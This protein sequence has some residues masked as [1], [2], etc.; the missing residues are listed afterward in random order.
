MATTVSFTA[1]GGKLYVVA[2]MVRFGVVYNAFVPPFT[3][4]ANTRA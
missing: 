1:T 3:I 4:Y 2:V